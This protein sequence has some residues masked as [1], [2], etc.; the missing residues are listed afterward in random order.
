MLDDGARVASLLARQARQRHA[1]RVAGL[2]ALVLVLVIVALG[3][4]AAGVAVAVLFVND[5]PAVLRC[6]LGAEHARV[7]GRSS[8]VD[9]SGGQR[10]GAVP[11]SRNR[12]PVPLAR[13]TPWLAQAT[14]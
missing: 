11:S 6:D 1:R 5:P 10:L 14:I 9:A 13:M 7:L 4:A 3:V 8:F 12:E 2:R